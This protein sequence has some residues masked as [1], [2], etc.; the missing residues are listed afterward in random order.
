M[1]SY[2]LGFGEPF[3]NSLDTSI[4]GVVKQQLT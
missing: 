3:K 1:K 2:V 4:V